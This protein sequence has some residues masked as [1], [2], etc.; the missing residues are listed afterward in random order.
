VK[1]KRKAKE[2]VHPQ[3]LLTSLNLPGL[4]E[5]E[6]RVLACETG[7]CKRQPR[8]IDPV[9]F[10]SVLLGESV[11]SSPSYN[12]LA[13]RA[14][15]VTQQSVSRQA[16]WKRTNEHCVRFMDAI[17]GRAIMAKL[18]GSIDD[19]RQTCGA[20]KRVLVQDSTIIRLPMWL[21]DSYS[22]VGNGSSAVCNARVQVT[23]D[24]IA[25]AFISF[26]VD[27]Y[28]KNDLK[29][30]PELELHEGDLVL[31]DRGY[32]TLSEIER[33]RDA[34]AHCIYRH[35]RQ[36]RYLDPKTRHPIDLLNLLKQHNTIDM[37]VL[38]DNDQNT[39]VR[40]V[41]APVPK[42]LA[43]IRRRRLK[44]EQ[45]GHNPSPELLQLQAWT[46]FISTIPSEEAAFEALF[47][48]YSLRWWIEIIFKAWKS[49]MRFA[50]IHKVSKCQLRVLLAAR[51]TMAVICT[52]FVFQRAQERIRKHYRKELSIL[53][54]TRYLAQ[55]PEKVP[56]I[57]IALQMTKGKAKPLQALARYASYDKRK[58]LNFQQKQYSIFEAW[59][60]S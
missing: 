42:E 53:K 3:D 28:T 44:K 26:S 15:A 54:T 43:D 39:P 6:V 41:A 20:C 56:E 48:M 60:L 1:G 34:Q 17:L 29:A 12:D 58:R 50:Q 40:L 35:K 38:L 9:M 11:R 52:H 32:L 36:V 33:H 57:I 47:A 8:K 2:L 19:I 25:G 14:E 31:R 5:D 10:A 4:A 49:C 23:Y 46:I 7:F 27:P 45:N 55:N 51:M 22:G 59:G 18:P 16:M 30:A 37:P 21:F 13:A 24:L